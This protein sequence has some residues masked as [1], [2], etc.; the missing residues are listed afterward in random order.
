VRITSADLSPKHP[1]GTIPNKSFVDA[2]TEAEASVRVGVITRVDALHMKA[3][4][5]ILTGGGDRFEVDL[6]QGMAGP[7]SFFGGVPEVN[8]LVL[9]GYRQKH[10]NLTEAVI[11]GYL[12]TGNKG[13]YRF[14]PFAPDD[15]ATID[16]PAL[17]EKIIGKT[18]RYKRLRLAPGDIGAMSSRG[19]ELIVS[20]DF[21]ALNRAG[22]SFELRDSDRSAVVQALHQ[23]GAAAGVRS[24]AGPARRSELHL[25]SD[26]TDA[27][28]NFADGY[29]GQDALREQGPGRTGD[30]NK[31]AGDR[32]LSVFNDSAEFPPVVYS[33]GQ[34]AFYPATSPGVSVDED[35]SAEAYTEWRLELDHVTDLVQEVLKDTDGVTVRP[36][37]RYIEF[38]LG[39]LV[40]SDAFS[41]EGLRQ[42]G[43]VLK[44]ALFDDLSQTTQGR[45]SLSEVDRSPL[46]TDVEVNSMASAL[47]LKIDP[48][49]RCSG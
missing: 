43:R 16:D 42:Y 36:R 25:P 24:F 19:A 46:G 14:D 11:L 30:A 4:L 26:I 29:N 38:V 39:T 7:R 1:I 17:F 21:R 3:D 40:G 33:T 49:S 2:K 20:E 28:G 41:S 22:D 10:K 5:R 35:G 12:P 9:V 13:G 47:F 15:P 8:S 27:A 34:R 44:P 23:I 48:P 45:F 31:W 37:R 6:T 32:L 18:V